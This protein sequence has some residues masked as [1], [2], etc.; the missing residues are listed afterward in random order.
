MDYYI[1]LILN[2]IERFGPHVYFLFFC[3]AIIESFVLTGLFIPGTVLIVLIGFIASQGV[4]DLSTLWLIVAS[5]ALIGDAFSF[6]FGLT[7]GRRYAEK[8]NRLFKTDY[9][10]LGEEFFE[11]HGDKSILIGRFVALLRTFVPFTAGLMKMSKRKFIIWNTLSAA[12]WAGTYLLLGY[13][14]GAALNQVIIWSGRGAAVLLFVVVC[15]LASYI[16]REKI[17]AKALSKI[18]GQK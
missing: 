18:E 14:F 15:L 5:G 9:I 11:R 2:E 6:H 17:K 13:F 8:I 12:L 16:I 4:L 3:I 10:K 1:N 7:Q